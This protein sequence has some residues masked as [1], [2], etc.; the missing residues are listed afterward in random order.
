MYR[1]GV[2][3]LDV[4]A[5]LMGST[6]EDSRTS[7]VAVVLNHRLT[8]CWPGPISP[9]GSARYDEVPLRPSTVASANGPPVT[10]W[11]TLLYVAVP[12]LTWFTAVLVPVSASRQ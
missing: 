7:F 12:A 1:F 4:L 3:V 5:L 11:V 8:D 2:Y 10:P 6:D 9:C